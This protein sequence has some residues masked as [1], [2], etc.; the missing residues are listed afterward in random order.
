MLCALSALVVLSSVSAQEGKDG[1]FTVS[2]AN[3]VLNRYA[4]LATDVNPGATTVKVVNVANLDDPERGQLTSGDLVMLYQTQGAS[5]DTGD[6]A[7]YGN[8]TGLNSAGRYELV[9][10]DSV[11]RAANTLTL[12]VP[13]GGLK[14]AYTTA[15]K[16]QVI[17]VPQFTTLTVATGASVTAPAW[18][19]SAGGVV[20]LHAQSMLVLNGS[21]SVSGRGFRGGVV[22]NLSQGTSVVVTTQRSTNAA[23]GAE[24][25]ESVAGFQDAYT[26]GRYGRGAPANGGGGGNSHNGGGGGGANGNNGRTWT[27]Q[28]VMDGTATGA[29]AWTKD[30]G[31][32]ANGN[33]LTNSS[34]GGRGGYTYSST[35]QDALVTGP[36]DATWGGNKRQAVGGL[37]GH[38][39][40]N[41]PA[42]RLF[43]GGGGGAGDAN[44]R[45]GGAGGAGGG[46]VFLVAGSVMGSG[47]IS[48]NGAAGEN[49]K[50]SHNDAPGGGGGGGTVVVK[51]NALSGVS[52]QASGGAGGNQ[53]ITA[54]EAE[55]PG[56]GGGGGFIAV[57]GG[58]VTQ[59]ASGAAG[60]ATTSSAL[61][62]FPANG[63]TGG[64]SGQTGANLSAVPVCTVLGG[65]L[66]L[67]K[68]V[69]NLSQGTAFATT[70]EG[71]P[72]DVLEYRVTFT[73][74]TGPVTSLVFS[75]PLPP[76]VTLKQNVYGALGE[77]RVVC[78]DGSTFDLDHGSASVISK[79]ISG[80]GVCPEPLYPGV[81][82]AV[83][84]QTVIR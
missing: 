81:S 18:N 50:P 76:D 77:L 25:G 53:L 65:E 78:S 17:R 62:E 71:K 66:S 44:N 40:G 54:A 30:P 59:T 31:Y 29:A 1:A 49:S 69:R 48:A 58:S 83:Y 84:F 8:V 21:V 57:S 61:T 55:G 3:T 63:A 37:G 79:R 51:T 32:I 60:G 39:L 34:G 5:I 14:F 82:G 64:A 7:T 6:S 10:L 74:Q 13:C 70:N 15:G 28:G 20:A 41:D 4:V 35:N 52:V 24:K 11:D 67:V 75:D 33:A 45:A 46:L 47:T 73:V 26:G 27:G 38:P 19:G 72:G 42:G 9:A 16:T 22:D 12:S 43:L 2:A 56:G 80:T 36:S 68:D 23:D